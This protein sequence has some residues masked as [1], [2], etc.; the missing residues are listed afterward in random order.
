M[1]RFREA[2]SQ[3]ESGF[4]VAQTL[5]CNSVYV[6]LPEQH[7]VLASNL[8]LGTVS[9]IE[10]NTIVDLDHA[11]VVADRYHDTPG[12]AAA[13]S[14]GCRYQNA[15]ATASLPGFLLG[16]HENPVMKHLNRQR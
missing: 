3:V 5:R 11:D 16:R 1:S 13:N 7:I 4:P 9:G 6:A 12:Q 2:D 14:H 10:Q 15:A 8:H